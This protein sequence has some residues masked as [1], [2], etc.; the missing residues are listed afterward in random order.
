MWT[1]IEVKQPFPLPNPGICNGAVLEAVRDGGLILLI[2]LE[3]MTQA[4]TDMLREGKISVRAYHEQDKLLLLLRFGPELTFEVSFN[5][6]RYQDERRNVIG[7]SNLLHIIG[8]DSA[9]NIVQFQRIASI[10]TCL[11]EW[12]RKY[13]GIQ[14][15][16]MPREYDAWLNKI[17]DQYSVDELWERGE[18]IGQLGTT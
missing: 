9:S 16:V 12:M 10:P 7:Q 1:K 14:S 3:R 5:L 11:L 18:Y 17:C 13:W 6:H 8:I 15:H 4:E 2:Y